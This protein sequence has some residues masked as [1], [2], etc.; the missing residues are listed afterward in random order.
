[1]LSI[2]IVFIKN[3]AKTGRSLTAFGQH[4]AVGLYQTGKI[5]IDPNT[6][7]K[8]VMKENFGTDG[9]I[10]T[11]LFN[12][13]GEM[14]RHVFANIRRLPRRTKELL[15]PHTLYNRWRR[16]GFLLIT[17]LL[18]LVSMA[19][20]VI[21]TR[22]K[23]LKGFFADDN[24]N[25]RLFY[26][27]ASV[28]AIPLLISIFFIYTREHYLLVLFTL[29]AVITAKNLPAFQR[30][31]RL[32]ERFP[33]NKFKWVPFVLVFVLLFWVPW[34]VTGNR[35]FLPQPVSSIQKKC[36]NLY[37][38]DYIKNLKVKGPIVFLGTGGP[39]T[40]YMKN[41]KHVYEFSKDR[42][43]NAFVEEKKINMILVNKQL[44][45]DTRYREDDE[46]KAFLSGVPDTWERIEM[47]ACKAYL[48]VRKA[49]LHD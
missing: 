11:A 33:V 43:F 26:L 1:M 2:F 13:P 22:K 24:F 46:F 31:S 39:M 21:E 17:G 30:V 19:Y 29:L 35:G 42:P 9:S 47:P 18:L 23:T 15:L 3:P 10:L 20:F 34:R 40:A 38:L 27:S 44:I 14:A 32:P 37:R 8:K 6:N 5:S 48:A 4:Y 49:L 41:F 36:P 28:I 45:K 25:D 12:N 7:W 16:R